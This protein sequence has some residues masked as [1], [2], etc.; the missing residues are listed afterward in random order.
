MRNENAKRG[1]ATRFKEKG[2]M[3]KQFE[4]A[5]FKRLS[6]EC[7]SFREVASKMGMSYSSLWRNR[8]KYGLDKLSP[9]ADEPQPKLK[10]VILIF[11]VE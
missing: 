8:K 1:G 4:V 6:S 10:R 11:E 3:T 2:E 9:T 5:E 7:N